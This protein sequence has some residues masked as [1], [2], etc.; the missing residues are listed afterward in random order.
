MGITDLILSVCVCLRTVWLKIRRK[1][2][3]NVWYVVTLATLGF[4]FLLMTAPSV[5]FGKWWFL[6]LPVT[7]FYDL[8]RMERAA[9]TAP[10]RLRFKVIGMSG[11]WI[12][13][14]IGCFAT[15]YIKCPGGKDAVTERLLKPSDYTMKGSK[16]EYLEINGI[17]F[18]Y[19]NPNENGT[20]ELNGYDGFPGTESRD[21]LTKIEMRGADLKDGFR[22]KPEF[23]K[24]AYDFRGEVLQS[25]AIKALGLDRYYDANS[26]ILAINDDDYT[27]INN[28]LL[29]CIDAEAVDED[30]LHTIAGWAYLKGEDDA[31]E[32]EPVKR[33]SSYICIKNGDDYYCG[34]IIDRGDVKETLKLNREDVGFIIRMS[35]ENTQ[36]IYMIDMEQKI[37]YKGYD[38]RRIGQRPQTL[39]RRDRA[40]KD[41]ADLRAED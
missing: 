39:K 19:Y 35:A 33:V 5:R 12:L 36:K 37:I 15:M 27:I 2:V 24:L 18:Y 16:G 10:V 14:C 30:N 22:P 17:K 20:N 1:T 8:T 41:D 38:I 4:L 40:K 7:L 29:Y 9:G 25:S 6:A 21:T 28:K 3:D 13:I 31:I 23:R 26:R 34:D 32:G 11:L